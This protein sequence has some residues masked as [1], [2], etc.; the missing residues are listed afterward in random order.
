MLINHSILICLYYILKEFCCYIYVFVCMKI[1]DSKDNDK[2][3]KN[4]C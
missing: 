2:L 4:N 3:D 1:I